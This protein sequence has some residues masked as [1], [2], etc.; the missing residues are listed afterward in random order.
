[1]WFFDTQTRFLGSAVNCSTPSRAD[2]PVVPLFAVRWKH[3]FDSVGLR[4]HVV[5]EFDDSGPLKSF[6][7]GGEGI[8]SV[9]TAVERGV[10][11][12]YGVEILGRTRAVVERFYA[13]TVERR[14]KHSA[15]VAISNAAKRTLFAPSRSSSVTPVSARAFKSRDEKT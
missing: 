15:V 3:W 9:P 11:Q 13:I 7:Q 4:P 2:P 12:Q 5:A 8:F 10:C 6:G 1:M 14:I